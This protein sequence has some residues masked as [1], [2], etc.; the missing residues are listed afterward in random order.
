MLGEVE[1]AT[2]Q[3]FGPLKES[4]GALPAQR[5]LFLLGGIDIFPT[6]TAAIFETALQH[7]STSVGRLCSGQCKCH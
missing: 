5:N 2:A 3:G 6:T 7:K 4:R 1:V